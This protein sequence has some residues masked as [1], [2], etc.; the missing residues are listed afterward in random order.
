[1]VSL[2]V[3]VV[4]AMVLECCCWVGVLQFW[5]RGLQLGL[6]W[7]EN[8]DDGEWLQCQMLQLVSSLLMLKIDVLASM[9][10]LQ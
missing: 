7:V 10:N 5:A 2:A 8:V 1:M 4:R 9:V 6:G 3:E